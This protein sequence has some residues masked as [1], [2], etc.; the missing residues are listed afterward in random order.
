MVVLGLAIFTMGITIWGFVIL[1][2]GSV[3]QEV[4]IASNN[5]QIVE[6]TPEMR[7]EKQLTQLRAENTPV[8]TEEQITAQL[9][10]L[11]SDTDTQPISEVELLAQLAKINE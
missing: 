9:E 6:D 4:T 2:I 7:V 10:A 8:V 1:G 11:K 5:E 3:S